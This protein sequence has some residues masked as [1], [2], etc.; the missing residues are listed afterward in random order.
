MLND[1][2]KLAE[3][4]EPDGIF[5]FIPQPSE[6]FWSFLCILILAIAFYKFVLPKM[7]AVLKSR[8]DKIEGEIAS[9]AKLK[10][11]A[12]DLHAKYSA[13][14]K[15][16]RLDAASIRD[17]ARSHAN[18]IIS[19]ARI[20]AQ[21]EADLITKNA[22]RSIATERKAAETE[23]KKEIF[24]L[25]MTATQKMLM[26]GVANS[27]RQSKLID[28]ALDS[29]DGKISSK[30]ALSNKHQESKPFKPLKERKRIRINIA[31]KVE[32]LEQEPLDGA[33]VRETI[34][35]SSVS[36]T[37]SPKKSSEK[38]SKTKK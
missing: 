25:S 13:E 7:D 37:S 9:A 2:A 36:N 11:E 28:E 21:S 10:N 32:A 33:T 6:I 26:E 20:K 14:V 38:A 29:F 30:K 3:G 8:S 19:D 27:Q 17:D 35:D 1:A 23:L 4:S 22:R 31:D 12:E 5:L 15:N 18:Q 34:K 24:K 16:A